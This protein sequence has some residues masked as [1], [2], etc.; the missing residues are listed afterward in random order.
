MISQDLSIS[1][2]NRLQVDIFQFSFIT[3]KVYSKKFFLNDPRTTR[4]S[5]VSVSSI[6]SAMS[7]CRHS[8]SECLGNVLK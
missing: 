6:V 7:H 1:K 8:Y 4:S 3:L 2:S 5:T